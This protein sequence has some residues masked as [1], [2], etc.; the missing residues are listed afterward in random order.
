MTTV[1]IP[2]VNVG[3]RADARA[4]ISW[5]IPAAVIATTSIVVGVIWDI[6]WHRTIGRDTFWTPAHMAIYLGG[7]LAGLSGAWLILTTTFGREALRS[8]GVRV[9]GFRGPLG[10]WI[11]IWGAT[12][13]LTSAPF[14]DWW[15][16][17]YGLDVKILSP[18]HAVL[19]LGM[20]TIQIGILMLA[21]THQNRATPEQR[22]R[23]GRVF[24][25]TLGALL[26]LLATV[27]MEHTVPHAQHKAAFY[28]IMAGV[29]LLFLVAASRA[30]SLRWPA[31]T[32]TAVYMGLS[33]AMSWILPLFAARPLLGPIFN[34]VD[35]MVPPPFPMLLVIPGLAVDLL[36]QRI[37]GRD[38]RLAAALGAA[39]VWILFDVQWWFA[40]FMVSPYSRDIA[41]FAAQRWGYN[42][43]Q[44]P[45]ILE[46]WGQ[47]TDAVTVRS[48][49]VATLIGIASSRLALGW[50][51]WMRRV[52]R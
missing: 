18:P 34:P 6:S 19:G 39:F 21:L 27:L 2:G 12:A 35:H 46:F 5:V 24:A 32:A 20:I 45:A 9:W 29:F 7:V 17:A 26:A 50:G 28:K 31:T 16:N 51:N 25:Y 38:W 8:A 37:Q 10:A 48:M 40:E 23:L 43:R 13:M 36:M 33:A 11:M 1:S 3:E 15:H 49:V 4:R 14:D 41:F 52:V 44:T 30:S 22:A 42:I 47:T